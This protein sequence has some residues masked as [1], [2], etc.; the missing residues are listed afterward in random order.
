MLQLDEQSVLKHLDNICKVSEIVVW[1]KK[2]L[3][4][5]AKKV[6]RLEKERKDSVGIILT[7]TALKYQMQNILT[8]A[9]I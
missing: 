6:N 9:S 8:G 5:P 2:R 3:E 7:R 4:F 1:P